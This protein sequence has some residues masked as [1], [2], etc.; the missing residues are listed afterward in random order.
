MISKF[1]YLFHQLYHLTHLDPG[2]QLITTSF[3]SPNNTESFESDCWRSS[4]VV[5]GAA[6]FVVAKIVVVGL[7]VV[8]GILCGEVTGQ[9]G[10]YVDPAPRRRHSGPRTRSWSRLTAARDNRAAV[11]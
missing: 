7:G 10:A 6:A 11:A 3:V 5:T 1:R 8:M 4:V 9:S 2:S